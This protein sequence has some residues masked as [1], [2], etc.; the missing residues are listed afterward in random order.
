[1]LFGEMHVARRL[2]A[3]LFVMNDRLSGAPIGW[4]LADTPR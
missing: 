2:A 1:M 3:E 4:A